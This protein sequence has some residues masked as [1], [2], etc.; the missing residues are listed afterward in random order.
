M[1]ETLSSPWTRIAAVP[2]AL[3]LAAF[4]NCPHKPALET[5]V[6]WWSFH[7]LVVGAVGE[8]RL[9]DE[10]VQVGGVV[11][12]T[13]DFGGLVLVPPGEGPTAKAEVFSN[14]T[15][16]TYWVS[17]QAPSAVLAPGN[18]IGNSAE[19]L[20]YQVFRKKDADA[21]LQVVVTEAFL[22]GVDGNPGLPTELECPWRQA[23]ADYSACRRTMWGWV[24]FQVTAFSLFDQRDLLR[25]G[26]FAEITGWRG[27][28]DYDAYTDHDATTPFWSRS[29]FDLDPD[30][31]DDGGGHAGLRLASPI[32]IDVPLSSVRVGDMFYLEVSAKAET[33]NHRQRESYLAAFFRDPLHSD[34]LAFASSGLEPVETPTEKP[35]PHAP[36]PA[37]P[38]AT[39]PDP[40][41]GTLQLDAA[42]YAAPELPGDGAT[43]VVTRSG[44]SRGAVSATFRT[45]DGTAIAGADYSPVSTS[46]LFADGESGA[47]AVRVPILVDDVAEPDETVN[48][49]LS[50]PMG[51]ASLG[52][53]AT[54]VLTIMDDDRPGA[55]QP[56]YAIGG[57]VTGLV[58]T[59]LVLRELFSGSLV[60]PGNG[61]FAFP[62]GRLDGLGYDVRVDSQPTSPFQSCAVANGVGT[63]AA[64]DVTNVVVSCAAP[65]PNGALDPTF[66]SG[67][68]VASGVLGSPSAMAL[69]ADGKIL[70]LG[71]LKLLRFNGGGTPDATFGA[72]GQV[73]VP[74]N[75]SVFDAALGLAIQPDGKIVVV[76]FTSVAGQDDF[77]LA[78]FDSDGAPDATFGAGGK[79]STDFAGSGD[80]AHDVAVQADGKLVVSGYASAASGSRVDAD[81]AVARYEADGALD[82]TF[83]TGG[84][85]RTDV[86][87]LADFAQGLAIQGDG[88]IVLV[89]RAGVDGGADPDFGIVRYAA[90]G[91]PDLA[92]GL[93]G[94]VRT[95][96]GLGNWEEATDVA[97]QADG[98]VVLAGRVRIGAA[99]QLALARFD[100][101]GAP[102]GAFGAAG[103][104]TAAFSTQDDVARSI[105]VQGDG[106]IVVAGQSANRSANPDFAVARFRADGTLDPSFASAGEV[107]VDFF[108]S[109]DGAECVAVQPDGM[110]VVGGFARNA[111]ATGFALARLAP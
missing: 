110:I 72:S 18:A 49:T 67:G 92:F 89:G 75:G 88:K 91:S 22:E 52:A 108:G 16:K 109:I 10:R 63:I 17:A 94:I 100:A 71:G 25:T 106:K 111:G 23:G 97:L 6:R 47:R 37:A 24:A 30:V 11:N 107:T 8:E 40:E 104:A 81:F 21:S 101:Q 26:G 13:I 65:L 66:G 9:G 85:V 4:P 36:P 12:E 48:L 29:S 98:K 35:S 32:A 59:G 90:D 82:A 62:D 7:K 79:V 60:T 69:Q 55:Q 96:F 64:A 61:A 15:G 86:A 31:D 78:R 58:G 14:Q 50:E 53:T 93:G 51:C 95:D 76:G 28:W 5:M 73:A 87:G 44:G 38:C 99:F 74:F 1:A 27:A 70:L 54:A 84:K 41:A 19:L 20:Q 83:G 33:L 57:T 68:R 45:G 2:V 80:R 43:I 3:V 102:D 56:T 77:A 105:A 39:G 42:T 34:G 46:I 103:L